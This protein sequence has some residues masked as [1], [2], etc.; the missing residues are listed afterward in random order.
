M[1]YRTSP[2]RYSFHQKCDKKNL[3]EGRMTLETYDQYRMYWELAKVKDAIPQTDLPDLEYELR[4]SNYIH[5]KCV[6]SEQ[7]CC[8]LYAALCNN[9]FIKDDKEC[10]Y[11]WR[12]SGGIIA[13]ILE[14]GDYID[15]YVSGNEGNVTEE[16]REDLSK[17]GWII[18]PIVLEGYHD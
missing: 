12:T 13:N 14:K 7:Y 17:L 10:N 3:D 18:R 16:I 1:K 6:A 15:W 5:D 8:D 11:S 9:D 4:T 2:D